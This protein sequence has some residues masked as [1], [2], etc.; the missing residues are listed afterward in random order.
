MSQKLGFPERGACC[1]EGWYIAGAQTNMSQKEASI[2][3]G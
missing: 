3:H 2:D 1:N